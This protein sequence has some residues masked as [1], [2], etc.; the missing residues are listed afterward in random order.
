MFLT[1]L[2]LNPRSRQVRREIAEPYEMHR[3]LMRAFPANHEDRVLFRVEPNRDASSI[4]VL[5]QSLQKPDWTLAREMNSY[6]VDDPLTKVSHPVLTVGQRLQFRL[7]ANPTVKRDGKRFGIFGE[8]AQCAW[9]ARKGSENGFRVLT[10]QASPEGLLRGRKTQSEVRHQMT[11]LGVRFDGILE[12]TDQTLML[13][14]LER[15]LGSA[16]GFG[17]GLLTIKRLEL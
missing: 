10:A 17:F 15:G 13:R 12:I 1:Q 7:R 6:L 11:H 2:L 9:L 8:E 3:T 16:K 14:C 4:V 5:V